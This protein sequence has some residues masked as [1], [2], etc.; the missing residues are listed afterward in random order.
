[1]TKKHFI[2]IAR[3]I[4]KYAGLTPE[5]GDIKLLAEDLADI[6]KEENP[7][8]DRQRFLDACGL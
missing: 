6:F 1:M 4:E 3:V 2:K 5:R 8:F 7:A